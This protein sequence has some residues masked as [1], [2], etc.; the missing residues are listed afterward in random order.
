[1]TATQ[2]AGTVPVSAPPQSLGKFLFSFRGRISRSSYWI[3]FMLP[4]WV[5]AIVMVA[6]ILLS[7]C[8][9][10]PTFGELINGKKKETPAP[11]PVA[12]GPSAPVPAPKVELPKPPENLPAP[13]PVPMP[14]PPPTK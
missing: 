1:M 2:F 7:G 5:L 10:V 8:E 6:L 11:S 13:L 9:K 12:K 4:F 3:R 14:F